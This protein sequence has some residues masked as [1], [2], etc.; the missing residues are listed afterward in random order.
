MMDIT[1][2]TDLLSYEGYMHYTMEHE[3][4]LTNFDNTYFKSS[5][6]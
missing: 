6:Q 3:E 4:K 5:T 1:P 2:Y